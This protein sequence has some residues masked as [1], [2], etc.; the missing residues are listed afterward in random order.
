M[1]YLVTGATGMIG[2]CLVQR[3]LEHSDAQVF[4]LTKRG[5]DEQL[6]DCLD[7]WSGGKRIT[8]VYGDMSASML[9]IDMDRMGG[10]LA[11]V[12]HVIHLAWLSGQTKDAADCNVAGVGHALALCLSLHDPCLHFLSSA[13]GLAFTTAASGQTDWFTWAKREADALIGKQ[14]NVRSRIYRCG[15]VI[16]S[17]HLGL[18][19][20]LQ[21]A[22]QLATVAEVCLALLP[23]IVNWPENFASI[24]NLISTEAVADAIDHWASVEDL[25]PSEIV[26]PGAPGQGVFNGHVRTGAYDSVHL[27][28]ALRVVQGESGLSRYPLQAPALPS[29]SGSYVHTWNDVE[30]IDQCELRQLRRSLSGKVVLVTGGS[31]GIGLATAI[32]C[33]RAGAITII[34]G[35]SVRKLNEAR[36]RLAEEGLEVI[37]HR[38]D[39]ADE[40]SCNS[41]VELLN[42]DYG[43][44]DLLINNAG[45]SIRRCVESSYDSPHDFSRLMNINYFGALRLIMGFLPGMTARR[46]GHI[47]NISSIA[48]LTGMSHFSAYAASKAALEAWSRS[49]AGELA[50]A[51]IHFTTINM[52]L[53]RTPMSAATKLYDSLPALEPDEAASLVAQAIIG[54]QARI[55]SPDGLLG[56]VLHALSPELAQLLMSA[57]N[58]ESTRTSPVGVP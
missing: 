10:Q 29:D 58:A 56:G 4:V 9:G 14:K 19:A 38:A 16:N 3:L 39:V 42:D 41:L 30:D 44:V 21:A 51:G 24:T 18:H 45:H 26:L 1:K 37:A 46:A 12:D 28:Q 5:E 23:G 17:A 43:G 50:R 32:R 36:L 20:H 22:L 40:R 57:L 34:C 49:A 2:R 31:S 6:A 8:P 47:I 52:P 55:A 25:A 13:S 54:K 11:D 48:V 15:T 33:A 7:F 27:A 35:R 53:V